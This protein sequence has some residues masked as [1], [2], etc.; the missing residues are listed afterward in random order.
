MYK[1]YAIISC[2]E[3]MQQIKFTNPL[4]KYYPNKYI[5]KYILKKLP[6]NVSEVDYLD[7][8]GLEIKLPIL[9]SI[10]NEEEYIKAIIEEFNDKLLIYNINVIILSKELQNYR[11]DFKCLIADEKH[12]QFLYIN[13]VIEQVINLIHKELKD[14]NF[15]IID[16]DNSKT[17][18]I[19][20]NI[21]KDINSLTVITSHPESY[22]EI[23]EEI[24]DD[25][26][27]AVQITN[28]N[29]NQ[30]ISSDIIINCNQDN[31][32]VFYCFS[33]GSYII[34]F[35][36][37]ENKIRNIMI[38]RSDINIVTN[39]DM[40]VNNHLISKDLFHGVLL[41]ENR[42]IRSI[43]LYGYR[44]TMFDRLNTIK[45]KYNITIGKMYQR[46]EEIH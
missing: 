2:S 23:V 1:N 27:L 40:Y 14:M 35:V 18:Y 6:L 24:Y 31:D 25:T 39:I 15:V 41:N 34:D 17:R 5:M 30:N 38:K 29:V 7:N 11:N 20:D 22:E 45:N 37:D 44:D 16:G 46:G 33:E 3:D 9:P 19:I 21:Y 32:K 8:K 10:F 28:Y 42:I 26:G 4:I 13:K 43:Y 12:V 36:S